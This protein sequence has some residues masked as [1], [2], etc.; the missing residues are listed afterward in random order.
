MIVQ[1]DQNILFDLFMNRTPWAADAATIW[2]AHVDGRVRAAV[3]GFTLPTVFYV[4]RRHADRAQARTA[5]QMCI[6]TLD[7]V[8]LEH[9]TLTL[10]DSI[11]GP[12]FE[13]D[14]QLACAMQF[15]ADAV[16]TRDP[17][18]FPNSTL[19]VWSPAELIARLPP[20]AT[21]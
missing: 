17:R 1:L 10:A 20:A 2:Q 16:V 12:D 6:S 9:S 8:P 7:I 21:P 3:A 14:L 4:L 19:P 15:S 11:N 5:I 13:D 18:G